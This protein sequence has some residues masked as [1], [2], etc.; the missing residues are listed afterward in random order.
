MV[1]FPHNSIFHRKQ[2]KNRD[3]T[4]TPNDSDVLC[5][6]GGRTFSHPGNENY[7]QII[8]QNK[9]SIFLKTKTPKL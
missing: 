3:N 9:V 1:M 7:R 8:F 6:R 2:K 4:L 5:G